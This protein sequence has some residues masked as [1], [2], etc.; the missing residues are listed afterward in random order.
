MTRRTR[1][2]T[3]PRAS[4][5]PGATAPTATADPRTV[6]LVVRE[7]LT[8]GLADPFLSAVLQVVTQGV[9]AVGYQPVMLIA[10]DDDDH[11]GLVERVCA[12]PVA[13]VVLLSVHA[14][15]P[16]PETLAASGLALVTGGRPAADHGA[17]SRWVDVDN[18]AGGRL[19]ARHLL[20]RGRRRAVAVTG[21]AD[22]T[23]S[24]DRLTGFAAELHAAG[25]DTPAVRAGGFTRAGGAEAMQALLVARPDLDAVFC[26][27]DMMALG[28]LDALRA[29]GRRVP[30]EVAVVGFDDVE[31]AGRAVPGLTTVRQ[32]LAAYGEA[33]VDLLLGQL[34]GR[35]V[36]R[37][38][39]LPPEL[40]VRAST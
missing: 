17:A 5:R 22:M 38:R 30:D 35:H 21:P 4:A 23:A 32:P 16:L 11:T 19:V 20:G 36:P 25:L 28:A 29:A 9:L 14:D 37:C 26:F 27:N 31:Q 7:P 24:A 2:A 3:G 1:T 39:V 18:V 13:G 12:G 40:V 34:Q 15:D 8:F 6:A 33:L 10:Q